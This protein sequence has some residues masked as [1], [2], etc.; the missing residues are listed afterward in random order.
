MCAAYDGD[1]SG[2][3]AGEIP[4]VN[5]ISVDLDKAKE[6]FAK[7]VGA[8]TTSPVLARLLVRPPTA[9]SVIIRNHSGW[10]VE[11][12][13]LAGARA[14]NTLISRWCL[15]AIFDE[16]PRMLGQ[17]D[18]VVNLDDA[19]TALHARMRPG[20]QIFL[21]GSLWAPRGPVFELVSKRFGKPGPDALVIIASGPQLRPDLYTPEY[22]EAIRQVDDRTYES[23][24]MSRFA[25]PEDALLS[26]I[27]V[28]ASMRASSVPL[29]W[30]HT[31][32]Y[33]AVMDPATRG[34]GWTLLVLTCIAPGKYDIAMAR[35]WTGSRSNPLRASQVLK[36]MAA[37]LL[38][39]QLFDVFTD[40]WGFDLITDIA[41]LAE[42]GLSF[43][44]LTRDDTVDG[45]EL[46]T[47]LGSRSLSMPQHP[48]LRADLIA[49]RR[50]A[51]QQGGSQLIFP[52]T[53]DGRHCDYAAALLL[54]MQ[55]RPEPPA[56]YAEPVRP[57]EQMVL[58]RL[59][60]MRDQPMNTAID[61]ML[62]PGFW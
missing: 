58:E 17:S 5:I 62:S 54:A 19:L 29:P 44:L 27:D 42:T 1:C 3:A 47:L 35:E 46:E 37:D 18:A 14:G 56:A 23:D 60:G 25:D 45:K 32:N 51:R 59:T 57:D 8:L 39:Y 31:Q 11:I 10:P 12:K 26:S 15:G 36:E 33:I 13:M 28:A 38:C 2:L 52:R 40:Q 48:Q 22:C 43:G 30:V 4:R 21:V 53:A 24:V 41:E 49:V 20:A 6:T 7:L 9:D 61:R 34:N 55:V 50:K 16:A